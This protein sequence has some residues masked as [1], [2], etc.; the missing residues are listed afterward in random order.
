M[1]KV[2]VWVATFFFVRWLIKKK[3]KRLG[4]SLFVASSVLL[5]QWY[6]LKI[7]PATGFGIFI[8][9]PLSLFLAI[10]I[11]FICYK[12]VLASALSR[13]K[14]NVYLVI[15]FL[16]QFIFQYV[17]HVQDGDSPNEANKKLWNE[18]SNFNEVK[19]DEGYRSYARRIVLNYKF[20]HFDPVTII[21]LFLVKPEHFE[22]Y[23][24]PYNGS[25][26]A[27]ICIFNDNIYF[28]DEN[29]TFNEYT[30]QYTLKQYNIDFEKS[31]VLDLVNTMK[32]GQGF[33][34]PVLDNNKPQ[35]FVQVR[36]RKSSNDRP[37]A[38]VLPVYYLMRLL[39]SPQAVNEPLEVNY[40]PFC[41]NCD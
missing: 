10:T 20:Q 23:A 28:N 15:I 9:V 19:I 37:S 40:V 26:I 18:V 25:K 38:R 6:M 24:R 39:K 29:I 36:N 11:F 22:T 27:S 4:V 3:K 12:G 17:N 8:T 35:L 14:K 1:V 13:S 16:A 21:H 41:K 7:M 5:T 30:N 33:Y 2:I 32:N 31:R 34:S